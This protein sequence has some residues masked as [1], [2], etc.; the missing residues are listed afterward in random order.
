M[1]N[2]FLYELNDCLFEKNEFEKKHGLFGGGGS[3]Q[4][5]KTT[6]ISQQQLS[7]EQQQILGP[8][9][10][11]AEGF[12]NNPP[13]YYPGESIAPLTPL[14]QQAQ[15]EALKQVAP[16]GSVD[17]TVTGALNFQNFLQGDALNPQNNQNLQGAIEA[18]Q[19]PVTQNFTQSVLPNIRGEANL[20]NNFGSNRQG[21]AEGIASQAYLQSLS[22]ISGK[23]SF[24]AYQNAL[25]NATRAQF[26]APE[27]TRLGLTNADVMASIGG[28]QRAEEQARINEAIQRFNYQELSPFLA[29]QAA[30]GLAFGF[31]GGP[32]T[33]ETIGLTQGGGGNA[34]A[35]ALGGA[36]SGAAIG[37]M[38]YPGV[39][40][41]VGALLGALAGGFSA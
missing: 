41:A 8:V 40:T 16:G 10:S 27:L 29:A 4:A 12:V 39:G 13:E 14:E 28:A 32:V 30:S 22:D 3:Q 1:R 9:A 7:P 15:Q 23:L 38:L 17:Q 34:T 5:A 2:R 35:G 18:A 37:S 11:V 31:P 20:T 26:I 19:R 24:E 36:A 6:T 25:D 33:S 21:I